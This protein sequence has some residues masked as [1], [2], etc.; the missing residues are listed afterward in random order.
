MKKDKHICSECGSNKIKTFIDKVDFGQK[1]DF[2]APVRKCRQCDFRW[3][4]WVAEVLFE[5]Y[6]P[7]VEQRDDLKEALEVVYEGSLLELQQYCDEHKLTYRPYY[8]EPALRI[9]IM[10]AVLAQCKEQE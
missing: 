10:N 7:L 6:L 8:K 3:T 4:D 2:Y 1:W 5:K 9:V